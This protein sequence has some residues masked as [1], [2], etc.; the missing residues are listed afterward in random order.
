MKIGILALQGAVDAH[1][2]SL[3]RLG[4]APV[5]VRRSEHLDGI[6]A[7]VLP[8]GESTTISM[9]LERQEL[10]EPLD[11][12]LRGGLPALGTCAG[13]ILL[14]GEVLDGRADQRSFGAIDLTVRRN[15]FGRQVDSFEADLVIDGLV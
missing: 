14:A 9:L 10:F 12:R 5:E 13:M 6:D 2:R 11:A 1:A 3:S 8:G 7:I 4:A 15:A